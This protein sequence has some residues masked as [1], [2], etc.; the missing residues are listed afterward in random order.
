MATC[1]LC[2]DGRHLRCGARG[3]C[4]CTV[5]SSRHPRTDQYL[6][7]KPKPTAR[8]KPKRQARGEAERAHVRK[9]TRASQPTGPPPKR[10]RKPISQE[11]GDRICEAVLQLLQ[12]IHQGPARDPE[13]QETSCA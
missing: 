10:G 8:A 9:T 7:P 13:S 6:R 12:S 4:T 11:E 5:C 3:E 1:D 2:F